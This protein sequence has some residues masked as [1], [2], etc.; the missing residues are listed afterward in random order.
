M[1][2]L[3]ISLT[4]NDYS[5]FS[6]QVSMR[7]QQSEL[8]Q[9]N[10]FQSHSLCRIKFPLSVSL[11]CGSFLS[12]SGRILSYVGLFVAGTMVIRYP[13]D[14]LSSCYLQPIFRMHFCT[15]RLL[16]I[17][18]SIFWSRVG[19]G[20]LLHSDRRNDNNKLENIKTYPLNDA[21][22]TVRAQYPCFL[23][24]LFRCYDR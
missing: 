6:S 23:A 22:W 2:N 19:L 4:M 15:E 16:W 9:V 13:C 18:H 11:D 14:C 5:I 20:G 7:L 12:S 10:V 1:K 3:Q 17:L 8:N 24:V 21:S